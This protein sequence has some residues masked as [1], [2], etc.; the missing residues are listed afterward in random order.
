MSEETKNPTTPGTISEFIARWKAT[1]A[2]ERANCQPFLTALC[3]FVGVLEPEGATDTPEKDAYVFER[4][5]TFTHPDGST[6]AGFIDLYKRGC[7][8]LEAKQG[9]DQ[10]SAEDTPLWSGKGVKAGELKPKTKKGT[11]VRGTKGWDD[12]M[13]RARAQAESYAKALPVEEGWPPFLIITDVGHSIE[14]F[15]DFSLTGKNYTHFPGTASFRIMIDDLESEEVRQRLRFV[16]TDPLGLDP[17]RKSDKVTREIGD[18]LAALAKSLEGAGHLPQRVATF[19]MRCLFTMFAEDVELIT[20]D[21][22][23]HMMERYRGRAD[24][25]H[26]MA[27]SLWDDMNKGTEYSA[28]L[29]ADITRFNGGLFEN[30]DAIPLNEEQLELLIRAAEAD[31][32]DVEPAIFG[33]LLER[34]LEPRER[35]KLGAHY[36]PR[37][38]VERLVMPTVIEPLR[39]EW[40][41]VKT[42]AVQLANSGDEKA[43]IKE[44]KAFHQYLCKVTVLDPACGS[45]NFLYITMEHMKRLEGEVLDLAHEL[46]EDQYFLEMD[47]H[48]VDPHQFLGLE[49]NPRAVP[50]TELVLWIGH[51]QWHFKTRGKTMPAQPV[52]RDFHNIRFQDALVEYDKTELVTD[53]TGKPISRWDGRTTKTHQTTGKEV[54]D[55]TARIEVVRYIKPRPTSWPKADFIVGNPPFI[56]GKDIKDVMGEGH[57][58][59]LWTAYNKKDVPRSADYVMYW[60][61]KAA[62]LTR[63]GKVRRFGFIT[64]N[65]IT[66]TFSR[67]VVERHL[68]EK[69]ALSLPFAVPDHPWVDTAYAAAVRIAM[70]VG[71]AGKRSGR[72]VIVKAEHS[73]KMG[74]GRDVELDTRIGKIHANLRIG[75]DLTSVH[76]LQSNADI[77]SP[78]VKLHGAGFI[79]TPKQA[80]EL[81][82]GTVEGTEKYIRPY[83]NGRDIAGTPREVMVIDLFGLT[84]VEVRKRYPKVYQHVFEHVKP[85]RDQNR[86]A[87]RRENWWLFGENNPKFRRSLSALPRY[88]TT[89]ETAKHR[90]FQFLDISFLPDNMLVNIALDDAYGLGVLSSRIHVLWT[91]AKGG[92]LGPTPRYNKTQCFDPFPFPDPSGAQKSSIRDIAEELDARRKKVQAE[93]P[94]ITLTD[95]YNV[96]EKLNAAETLTGNDKDIH[97]K[98][99]VSVLKDLHERLDAAVFEAYGWD[100]NTDDDVLL[101]NLVALNHQRA[102][103]EEAGTI[104]WLRPE[105]QIPASGA[106]MTRGVQTSLDVG[107]AATIVEKRPWP[108][109]L[110]EQVE[111]V[112]D[113]LAGAET[114]LRTED[115]ARAFTRANKKKIEEV[116]TTLVTLSQIHAVGHDRFAA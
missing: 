109:T 70:T 76:S 85:E 13:I 28:A 90:V 14:L 84:D 78:G 115:V 54:P 55:E 116:L 3:N 48:T 106:V 73:T 80:N 62:E 42:A 34:A 49:I 39:H 40:G 47:Q 113:V 16:W 38:Y 64:T 24:K 12:A 29:E 105:Y 53:E 101:E 112:R 86:R 61:H 96:L 52:L 74:T 77:S 45:G 103:E 111:A 58:E 23:Q 30:V 19:L 69:K 32:R 44:V 15:A 98:G 110:P 65:S 2:S 81:G 89:V 50:I 107:E 25:F 82:L 56:G 75:A 1:S 4:P 31:W 92:D 114:P 9:S 7:F 22:F 97:E 36:T 79:V 88:I 68:R 57:Q 91:L 5:V 35:H 21:G 72:L 41:N 51:L 100:A 93:Q 6:S 67:R 11:A 33:T 18:M 83:R 17:T 10:K 37:A 104:R 95:M 59:A 108:K 94:E 8:V 102:E 46:G 99:L 87:Y 27:K 71:S 43:A 63:T 66:Q 60:W 20:K 26:L